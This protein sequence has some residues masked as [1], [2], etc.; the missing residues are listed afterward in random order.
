MIEQRKIKILSA[1]LFRN[2]TSTLRDCSL[3]V[4]PGALK[5][6]LYKKV[7]ERN[8]KLSHRNSSWFFCQ[9]CLRVTYWFFKDKFILFRTSM[10]I[11]INLSHNGRFYGGYSS[12]DVSFSQIEVIAFV[13]LHFYLNESSLRIMTMNINFRFDLMIIGNVS[14]E[15]LIKI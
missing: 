15:N 13:D 8:W 4:S 12:I 10:S 6:T 7:F 14:N 3:N 9:L 11:L 2:A 5:L 1:S